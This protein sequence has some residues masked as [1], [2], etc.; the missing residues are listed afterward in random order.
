MLKS[1]PIEYVSDSEARKFSKPNISFSKVIFK[2][3]LFSV[4]E[5]VE[6]PDIRETKGTIL[7]DGWT[8]NST[9]YVRLFALYNRKVKFLENGVFVEKYESLSSYI[10]SL[11]QKLM[12]A[13]KFWRRLNQVS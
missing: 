3:T 5:L 11:W 1:L 12:K 9:H 6:D 10:C 8:N 7:N 13:V 2:D 4:V